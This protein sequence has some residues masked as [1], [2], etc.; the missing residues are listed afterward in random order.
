M[1]RHDGQNGG[2]VQKPVNHVNDA[3]GRHDIGADQ[4][5]MLLAQQDLTLETEE[6]Q[7]T[8]M[9]EGMNYSERWG[10]M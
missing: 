3:V 5:G 7:E 10:E 4:V 9:R 6:E 2:R 8:L 1:V